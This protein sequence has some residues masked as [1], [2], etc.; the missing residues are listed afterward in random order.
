MEFIL[1]AFIG[2]LAMAAAVAV[3][4]TYDPDGKIT[5][6]RLMLGLEDIEE[7]DGDGNEELS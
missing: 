1:G 7:D 6:Y 5:E 3:S 4:I 2:A